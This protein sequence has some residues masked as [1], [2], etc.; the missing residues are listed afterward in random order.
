MKWLVLIHVLSAVI[1]VGPTFFGHVLLRRSQSLPD[2]RAN[3]KLG[4]YLEFFPK[5]GGSIAVLSGL[6]LIL[7]GDYGS[8]GQLWLYGS[9]VLYVLIQVVVIALVTPQQKKLANWV[10][11]PANAQ[12]SELPAEQRS[13][14]GKVSNLYYFAS[15]MG[16]LLF[17]FM[18]VKP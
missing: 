3:L 15:A 2:L 9:L 18:I 5:I 8:F 14:L 17:I 10:L 4:K 16:T 6:A 11:D 7:I 12:A 13:L 1:G